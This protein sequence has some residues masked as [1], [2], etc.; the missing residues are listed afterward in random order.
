MENEIIKIDRLINSLG[1]DRAIVIICE[2]EN[3]N[4]L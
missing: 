4:L 2:D 3:V 1:F